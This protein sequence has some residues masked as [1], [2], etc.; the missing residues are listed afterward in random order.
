MSEY[1]NI[2]YDYD[3][4]L[5]A[6]EEI[7]YTPTMEADTI[8][9]D[10]DTSPQILERIKKIIDMIISIIDTALLKI[11]NSMQ[12]L[13][14]T[15]KGFQ[16][17]YKEWVSKY[18]PLQSVNLIS[19][20]YN[21]TVL[22]TVL[23]KLK[24]ACTKYTLAF[25]PSKIDEDANPLN[26][27]KKDIIKDIIDNSGLKSVGDIQIEQEFFLELK[28][29][30]RGDKSEYNYPAASI[31]KYLNTALTKSKEY[32]NNINSEI[33]NMKQTTLKSKSTAQKFAISHDASTQ[34][35]NK[36]NAQLS[37]VSIVYNFY[38]AALRLIYELYIEETMNARAIIRK[39][40]QQ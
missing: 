20:Q 40:Y 29:E 28:K 26:K 8:S 22:S 12:N 9:S 30:F 5:Y 6:L 34:L 19:Y 10:T 4:N 3:D 36:F 21:D 23:S 24:S 18:K 7:V 33:A 11:K 27:D 1:L 35:K 39:L 37:K 31:S 16:S 13:Y 32:R 25:D 15:D 38:I 2:K 17:A 14:E